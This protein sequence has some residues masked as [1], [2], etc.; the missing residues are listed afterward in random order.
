MKHTTL[1]LAL[2]LL[3]L[4][5]AAAPVAVVDSD[6]P[7]RFGLRGDGTSNDGTQLQAALDAAD[8]AGDVKV[9]I[10]AGIYATT[11][12]INVPAGV[13]LELKGEVRI[14]ATLTGGTA[15]VPVAGVV[16]NS[17][18]YQR[19]GRLIVDC[20]TSIANLPTAYTSAF[21]FA[22]Q[23]AVVEN[24]YAIQATYGLDFHNPAASPTVLSNRVIEGR[25]QLCGRAVRFRT[26]AASNAC[27][28]NVIDNLLVSA[29]TLS[30]VYVDGG[31][32][33]IVRYP[34]IDGNTTAGFMALDIVDANGFR[35]G[36]WL[37]NAG[38]VADSPRGY[39]RIADYPAVTGDI[40]IKVR[41]DL[42]L[43]SAAT[44]LTHTASASRNVVV[45]GTSNRT[46]SATYDPASLVDGAGAT[47]TVSLTGVA[48]GDFVEAS[49]SNDL[50]GVT[51]TAWVSAANTVSVRFQNETGG[52]LDLA[53]GTLRAR[54][55]KA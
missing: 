33:N 10:P 41:S 37:E 1:L 14:E 19:G 5:A 49:F 3:A 43:Y 22:G 13:S 50:Q 44:G 12:T 27:N 28:A 8:A 9:T 48:L 31:D 45:E 32:D 42:G 21:R 52:T 25:A 7:R 34:R 24:V 4:P 2:L 36:G 54:V 16:F 35:M 23:N 26:D 53:S 51:L 20:N 46:G 30:G 6:P 15:S 17:T 39:V 11:T 29:C 55:R 18:S 38:A 40:E 47:T